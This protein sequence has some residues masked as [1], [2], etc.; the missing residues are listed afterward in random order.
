[1]QRTCE[2]WL[3]LYNKRVCLLFKVIWIMLFSF[4]WFCSFVVIPILWAYKKWQYADPVH[5]NESVSSLTFTIFTPKVQAVLM[6]YR[7]RC[8]QNRTLV[9]WAVNEKMKHIFK[10][11]W[12][13]LG[14][15]LGWLG[16]GIPAWAQAFSC[17][18]C[19]VKSLVADLQTY[20]RGNFACS[21]AE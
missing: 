13:R 21:C 3:G 7:Q 4:K 2:C 8:V 20:I 10:K 12:Q 19:I 1:M 18:L 14:L 17:C 9:T 6:E 11:L 16:E 15:E 5:S